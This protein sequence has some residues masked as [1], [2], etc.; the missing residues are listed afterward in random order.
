MGSRRQS[1]GRQDHGQTGPGAVNRHGYADDEGRKAQLGKETGLA[2]KELDRAYELL[3]HFDGD[4][5]KDYTKGGAS[6]Q[7]E[8]DEVIDK[9]VKYHGTVYRGM[10]LTPGQL[11]AYK[12]GA[13]IDLKHVTSFSSEL[14]PAAKW[15]DVRVY[16]HKKD[17]GFSSKINP[18]VLVVPNAKN[19]ARA[20]YIGWEQ[21]HEVL[22]KSTEKMRVERKEVKNG[23]TYVYMTEIK[24]KK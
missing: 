13:E 20:R 18:V 2:G 17:K 1:A 21:E 19:G 3:S 12:P 6:K 11:A 8:L 7:R 23:V 4:A 9:M 5:Y 16:N 10:A 15:A 14:E 24:K 22:Y